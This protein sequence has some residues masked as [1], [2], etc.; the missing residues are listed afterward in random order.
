LVRSDLIHCTGLVVDGEAIHER[1]ARCVEPDDF[2]RGAFAPES[3]HRPVERRV[4]GDVPEV[5]VGNIDF[6]PLHHLAEIEG[7]RKRVCG[8]EQEPIA[9]DVGAQR[10]IRQKYEETIDWIAWN[11]EAF[12]KKHGPV[13]RAVL[14]HAYYIVCF[15][16]ERDR[17][18]VLAVLD[19]RRS[20]EEPRSVVEGPARDAQ[21]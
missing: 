13:R 1:F 7:F 18:L 12:P 2:D 16:M 9:H 4:R 15:V 10:A 17:S 20:P 19:G 3:D 5:V 8:H 21:E 6:N 14:K 11:P